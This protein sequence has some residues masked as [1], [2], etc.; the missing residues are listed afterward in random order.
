MVCLV[1]AVVSFAAGF[2][3]RRYG[4]A[5][6][7]SHPQW[8]ASLTGAGIG[9]VPAQTFADVLQ[10]LEDSYVDRIPDEKPLT[11]GA[12]R[13]MMDALDDPNSRFLD[14]GETRD[15]MDAQNGVFHGIGAVVT[16]VA[17]R[18]KDG[19][20]RSAVVANV[21]PNSPAQRAGLRAG[22]VIAKI[23]DQWV[24]EAHA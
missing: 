17:T 5:S 13:Q 8:L 7:R 20:H 12:L 23:G 24:Y 15:V 10:A 19:E 4:S 2:A 11:Y 14:P 16:I 9:S 1:V 21:L 22:D 18:E 3:A 6:A